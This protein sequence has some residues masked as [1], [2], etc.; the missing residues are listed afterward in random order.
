MMPVVG[1]RFLLNIHTFLYKYILIHI[2]L[3]PEGPVQ[4][5][6]KRTKYVELYDVT[7]LSNTAR[8]TYF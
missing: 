3:Q 4:L 6:Y 5:L 2:N 7:Q 8:A 1:Y